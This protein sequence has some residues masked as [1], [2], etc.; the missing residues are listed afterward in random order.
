MNRN[1]NTPKEL[2]LF[3]NSCTGDQI[4]LFHEF[5]I[6]PLKGKIQ[7]VFNQT[8]C[9][10]MIMINVKTNE[11]FF[12]GDGKG[13][14]HNVDAGTLVSS[15]LVSP[16]YDFYIVSQRS[17]R[18]CSVPN[19]YKVIYSDSEIEEGILQET[20]FSQCFNYVNWTGSI[21]VPAIMQYA[22]KLAKFSSEVMEPRSTIP[23]S[24]ASKL[25]DAG[26]EGDRMEWNHEEIRVGIK[27]SVLHPG[28]FGRIC[29]I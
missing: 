8:I 9:L 7:E 28:K 23:E 15:G 5:F 13:G 11:R 25:Y 10:T 22:K 24:L 19:H 29:V 6:E 26:K 14:A 16:N 17:N 18:G 1:G 27:V 2:F 4:S 12:S 21:K 20:A 3:Q